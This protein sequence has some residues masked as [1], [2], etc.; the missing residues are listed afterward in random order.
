MNQNNNEDLI[1]VIIPTR[2]RVNL[3]KVAIESVLN[4][5]YENLE[6]FII[7]E[8]SNDSTPEYLR[9]IED[10]RVKIITHEQPKGGNIARNNGLKQS[11]GNYIAF[12]DDDDVWAK[13]KLELQLEIMNQ[14]PSVGI[15][16][17]NNFYLDEND[18]I[19]GYRNRGNDKLFES[20]QAL[21]KMLL[22]NFIGG[23]SFPLLRRSHL[24]KLGGFQEDLKSAQETNLFLRIIDCGA[25]V[26]I[27]KEPLLLYRIHSNNRISDS[28]GPK[29][30][31]IRQL[32]SYTEENLFPKIDDSLKAKVKEIHLEKIA[33]VYIQ[34]KNYKGYLR[35]KEQFI[36]ESHSKDEL[37]ARKIK[38]NEFK[39]LAGRSIVGKKLK[40]INQSSKNG[41]LSKKWNYYIV[42]EFP[43]QLS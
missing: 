26:F 13:R 4:Q 5:T 29:L 19:A 21:E 22:G 37:S 38:L 17:C 41:K 20:Q 24:E 16:S 31:G 33:G 35:E 34:N 23:A 3:L 2:N 28:Y 10:P 25:D 8:A 18:D 11:K 30:E 32:Y 14:R 9:S 6:L 7:D 1:S 36:K 42:A 15:V 12:L 40:K 43:N 39:T 27:L